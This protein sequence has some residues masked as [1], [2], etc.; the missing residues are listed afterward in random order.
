MTKQMICL[1]QM[2]IMGMPASHLL[3][4]PHDPMT[5]IKLMRHFLSQ[6]RGPRF[7]DWLGLGRARGAADALQIV[8]TRSPNSSPDAHNSPATKEFIQNFGNFMTYMLGCPTVSP[9]IARQALRN[10]M[11]RHCPFESQ[12]RTFLSLSKSVFRKT[13]SSNAWI[14]S[15]SIVAIIFQTAHCSGLC[16]L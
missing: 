6:G 14:A 12:S 4:I 7:D 1:R 5:K 3:R 13:G 9:D 15:Q 10:S 11:H 16:Q 2:Q 8:T